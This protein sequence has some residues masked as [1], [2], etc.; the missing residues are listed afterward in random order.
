[1]YPSPCMLRHIALLLWRPYFEPNK[2]SVCIIPLQ[3]VRDE[4]SDGA[5]YEGETSVVQNSSSS[6]GIIDSLQNRS[7]LRGRVQVRRREW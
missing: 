1:M 7:P 2:L 5:T 3:Q 6:R 4:V